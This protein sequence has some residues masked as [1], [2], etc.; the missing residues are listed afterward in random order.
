MSNGLVIREGSIELRKVRN[1]ANRQK[2]PFIDMREGIS[3]ANMEQLNQCLSMMVSNVF[4]RPIRISFD[5]FFKGECLGN[6]F[7]AVLPHDFI[8]D[9]IITTKRMPG[10]ILSDLRHNEAIFA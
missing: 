7:V 9:F 6:K 3:F 5:N 8:N 1:Y 2:I 10:R 4:R